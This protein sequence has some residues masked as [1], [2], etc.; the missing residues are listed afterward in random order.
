TDSTLFIDGAFFGEDRGD[1]ELTIASTLS[2]FAA[3]QATYPL[4]P[5]DPSVVEAGAPPE[6]GDLD[7][8]DEAM[9]QAMLEHM[10]LRGSPEEVLGRAALTYDSISPE[11]V[12]SPKLR[13]AL[14][15][16][17]G[18][19]AEPAITWLLTETNCTG[20]PVILIDFREVPDGGSLL[21][22][23][24]YDGDGRRTVS[25]RP[26][27]AGERI[28]HL[29]PLLAHEAVHCDG[30]GS[31]LE[32]VV[33]AS[34][35]TL[36]YLQLLSADPTLALAGTPLARNLNIDA[37]AMINSGRRYP[38]SIGVLQS[39]G[40]AQALPATNRSARSYAEHIATAYAQVP[41]QASPP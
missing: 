7:V 10:R 6:P 5:F 8:N 3:A 26:D 33:A 41:E 20:A 18:T 36:L 19:F 32:E 34:F 38:E 37:I 15:A 14:G 11:I 1:E 9:K 25:I 21:A 23:V 30:M 27:L 40:V 12:P 28:E 13:A 24:T 31:V 4:V 17:T 2:P 29:M 22:R 39:D 35:D 16:L